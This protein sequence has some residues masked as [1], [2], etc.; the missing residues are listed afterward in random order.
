MDLFSDGA[1]LLAYLTFAH[2]LLVWVRD[3][4]QNS[5]RTAGEHGANKRRAEHAE[6]V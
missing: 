1:D 4:I 2:S 3:R 5:A 6:E